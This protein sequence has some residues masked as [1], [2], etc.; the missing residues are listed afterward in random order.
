[1]ICGQS[2]TLM[3]LT[4]HAVYIVAA[5]YIVEMGMRE[6]ARIQFDQAGRQIPPNIFS[7][8][9]TRSPKTEQIISTVFQCWKTGFQG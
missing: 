3:V 5:E 9:Y 8:C 4:L 6:G 7:A 1:M 2:S